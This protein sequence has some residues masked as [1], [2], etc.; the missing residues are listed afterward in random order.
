[1]TDPRPGVFLTAE[2]RHLTMLNSEVEPAVLAPLVPSGTELD[3]WSGRNHVSAIGFLSLRT[4]VL[5]LR[6]P[7]H[8]SFEEANHCF[9][10]RR[11]AGSEWRR[12]VVFVRDLAPR[13]AVAIV[14][15]AL[16]G[17]GSAVTIRKGAP[18]FP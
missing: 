10:V 3:A 1:M 6:I 7:F 16:Y 11:K 9:N 12:G 13:W 2:R 5:D 8:T 4:R 17:D 15:R 18:V 14:A